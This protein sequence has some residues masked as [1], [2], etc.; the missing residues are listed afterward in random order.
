M[1]GVYLFTL[2]IWLAVLILILNISTT[3]NKT[4]L[5]TWICLFQFMCKVWHK[6]GFLRVKILPFISTWSAV[7]QFPF[8][9]WFKLHMTVSENKDWQWSHI[10]TVSNTWLKFP[11]LYFLRS[12][13]LKYWIIPSLTVTE[14]YCD[15][16]KASEGEHSVQT[17]SFKPKLSRCHDPSATPE[18]GF[19]GCAKNKE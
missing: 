1:S 6:P 15:I 4:I 3:N 19:W 5:Q 18:L 7:G 9:S 8:Y 16:L 12:I 2:K 14:C 13:A 11:V 10:C 17:T